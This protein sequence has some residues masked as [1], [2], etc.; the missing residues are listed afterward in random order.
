MP[1]TML[2]IFLMQGT[3]NHTFFIN[4]QRGTPGNSARRP[5]RQRSAG[6]RSPRAGACSG[7]KFSPKEAREA[8]MYNVVR[9]VGQV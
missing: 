2:A 7:P 9:I 8:L 4:E 1:Y 5:G 6:I 3:A